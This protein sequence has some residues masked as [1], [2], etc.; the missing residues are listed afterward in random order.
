MAVLVQAKSSGIM[1]S[2]NSLTFSHTPAGTNRILYV[3]SSAESVSGRAITGITFG[4]VPLTRYITS[5]YPAANDTL[6]LW[7]LI[8][9]S[10]ATGNIVITYSGTLTGASG[11]A[12]TVDGAKQDTPNTYGVT[13]GASAVAASVS[14][15]PSVDNCLILSALLGESSGATLYPTSPLVEVQLATNAGVINADTANLSQITAAPIT[16]DWTMGSATAFVLLSIAIPPVPITYAIKVG[17]IDRTADVVNQTVNINDVINDQTNTLSFT[18][19]DRNATGAPETDN[20]VIITGADGTTIFGGYLTEVKAHKK[21]VGLVQYDCSA[22]DYVR[23]LDRKVVHKSYEDMTDAAIIEDIVNTYC[24]GLGI[25][26]NNV[27]EGVTLSQISFNYVQVSHAFRKICDLTGR[28]W[29]IDYNKDIH[30]FPLATNVT[31]FN[32]TSATTSYYNLK[33]SKDATQIKNRVYVRGGTKLSDPTTYSQK[34]DGVKKK[35][36]LPDKPHDVSLT[37]NGVSKTLGIKNINTSG[38]DYYLNYEEKY[39]EQ[40]TGTGALTTSDTVAVTY[41]YDIPIL[42]ALENT[43]SILEHGPQEFAIFDKQIATT[44]AARDRASAE[45]TDYANNVVEGGF[46]THTTGFVAGQYININLSEYDINE[47][48]LIQSVSAKSLGAGLFE[49]DVKIASSKTMGI[50]RFLIELLEANRNII[51]LD[52]N[53]V[54]DELYNLGDALISDSLTDALT[55]DSAGPYRTWCADSLTTGATRAVWGLFEW[56]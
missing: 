39:V 25:T 30:Y 22:V 24:T 9:P 47:N 37:V 21:G 55:I 31:P 33:I 11:I 2:A 53:E 15:T 49:Y 26:F 13:S 34:G 56:F 19:I 6:E 28:N 8:N 45:L 20:E 7:Y 23:L 18:L 50:I 40:D 32:I 36:L 51:T 48:Y 44:Q 17:G 52:N 14:L 35:F 27:V 10:T 38:Y 5:D 42:I 16:T 43:A 3:F 12:I 4:G 46:T 54:V 41:S 29:Y 1:A